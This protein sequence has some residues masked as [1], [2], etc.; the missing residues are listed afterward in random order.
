MP[1]IRSGDSRG[2]TKAA[3]AKQRLVQQA[4]ELAARNDLDIDLEACP[5]GH[6]VDVLVLAILECGG[7]KALVFETLYN[8]SQVRFC[9]GELTGSVTSGNF[10]YFVGKNGF[11]ER[12][13][14]RSDDKE[15]KKHGF[16]WR[17]EK[18][19]DPLPTARTDKISPFQR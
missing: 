15:N 1:G 12:I 17:L 13:Q 8:S 14:S 3:E 6:C 10:V 19:V 2:R 5:C 18:H 11:V 4:R 16:C 9:S 7:N